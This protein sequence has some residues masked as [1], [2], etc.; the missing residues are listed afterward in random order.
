MRV[1]MCVRM[2]APPSPMVNNVTFVPTSQAPA[3][4]KAANPPSQTD[5]PASPPYLQRA[6][7]P[8]TFQQAAA[9]TAANQPAV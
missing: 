4:L 2:Q 1:C 9:A 8:P 7:P 6:S 5:T 3:P